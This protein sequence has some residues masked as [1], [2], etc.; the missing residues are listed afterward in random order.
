MITYL[1]IRLAAAKHKPDLTLHRLTELIGASL[2]ERKLIAHIDKPSNATNDT[3]M[4]TLDNWSAP[5]QPTAL[6]RTERENAAVGPFIRSSR[7][8]ALRLTVACK[9]LQRVYIWAET[10]PC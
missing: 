2:F 6:Q 5:M 4:L 3:A 10:S 7:L 9:R 8:P 1:L